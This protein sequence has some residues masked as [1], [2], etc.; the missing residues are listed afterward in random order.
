MRMRSLSLSAWCWTLAVCVG[1]ATVTSADQPGADP[2]NQVRGDLQGGQVKVL[3]DGKTLEGW[4]G[5]DDLWSVEGGAI[6]GRTTD[7]NPIKGNTFLIF[8]KPIEGDFELTLQYKIE[9]GNSG[10]Q[11]R[12]HVVDEAKFVISGYQADIDSTGRFTGIVYEEKGRGILAERGEE[13]VIGEDGEKAVDRFAGAD[14]LAKG[15][16][17]EQWNDYR[18]LVRGTTLEQFINESLMSRVIDGQTE[19]AAESGLIA[20]QLHRGP[21]MTVRFKNISIRT[22]D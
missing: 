9:G 5:R 14:E 11:Y 19:K 8:D 22:W 2:S 12:S 17:E 10:V 7:E 20:L 13:V 16:H 6:V 18:I 1:G 15:I 21:A 3:F 4:R